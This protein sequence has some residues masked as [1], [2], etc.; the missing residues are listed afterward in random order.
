MYEHKQRSTTSNRPEQAIWHVAQRCKELRDVAPTRSTQRYTGGHEITSKNVVLCASCAGGPWK[1]MAFKALRLGRKIKRLRFWR[2][3][4][5]LA[6][7]AIMI[8]IW[9]NPSAFLAVTPNSPQDVFSAP[10]PLNLLPHATFITAV[11][12]GIVIAITLK[13]FAAI[14]REWQRVW[15]LALVERI[16]WRY[17]SMVCN[18][19]D[20]GVNRMGIPVNQ[21]KIEIIAALLADMKIVKSRCTA[22]FGT[23]E[24]FRLEA[25]IEDVERWVNSMQEDAK[26]AAPLNPQIFRTAAATFIQFSMDIRK[27]S[28]FGHMSMGTPGTRIWVGSQAARDAKI[29]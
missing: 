6:W 28:G 12:Q 8:G 14:I 10:Q 5:V 21:V 3:A 13:W 29:I 24:L 2:T 26:H 23:K 9:L 20:F 16:S 4:S 25:L 22:C 1:Q 11:I 27:S 15:F 18:E 7:P 17:M 19:G